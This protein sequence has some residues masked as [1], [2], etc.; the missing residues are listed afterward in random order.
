MRKK[1]TIC[2][3]KGSGDK[4][5]GQTMWVCYI[6]LGSDRGQLIR[7]KTIGAEIIEIKEDIRTTNAM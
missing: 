3:P 1:I 7:P 5:E 6:K 2:L 4:N